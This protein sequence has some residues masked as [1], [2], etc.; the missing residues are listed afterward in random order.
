MEIRTIKNGQEYL[1]IPIPH[2]YSDV[3]TLIKSD[4]F[5][6]V[7]EEKSLLHIFIKTVLR[8]F[9]SSVLFW[10]RMASYKG[11]LYHFSL[12]M[13]KRASL[14]YNI[15]IPPQ[16]C[17]GFGFYIGHGMCI[18]VNGGTIIG[19]NVN[20]SQFVNIGTNHKTP[21]IIGDSVYIG[22]SSLIIE[23]VCIG[24]NATIGAGS[25]VVKDIPSNATV[26]GVPAIVRNYDLPGR[27]ISRKYPL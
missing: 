8:P 17:I 15:D 5:R 6:I 12:F 21:A 14:K 1:K 11:F 18:V 3:S 20:L 9:K 2:S 24:E 16:T 23:D 27:Y 7:G 22:A 13:Y 26:A 25:V 4:Y 19:N 10:L